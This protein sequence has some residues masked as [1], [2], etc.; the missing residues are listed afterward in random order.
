MNMHKFL[1]TMPNGIEKAISKRYYFPLWLGLI[2]FVLMYP[3]LWATHF[4][5]N[6]KD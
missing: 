2:A 1:G 4:I 6:G 3:I 5:T